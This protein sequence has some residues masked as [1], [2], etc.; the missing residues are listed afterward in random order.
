[1]DFSGRENAVRRQ[2]RK[3]S[4][5]GRQCSDG[6]ANGIPYA[7]AFLARES[8]LEERDEFERQ[9]RVR[10]LLDRDARHH[11]AHVRI[12]GLLRCVGRNEGAMKLVHA[13][14]DRV[15]DSDCNQRSRAGARHNR[16]AWGYP[17]ATREC[18]RRARVPSLVA[19]GPSSRAPQP[20]RSAHAL[21][22]HLEAKKCGDGCIFEFAHC[23]EERAEVVGVT[24]AGFE[25]RRPPAFARR[26]EVAR[27]IVDVG[28]LELRCGAVGIDAAGCRFD[29]DR[30]ARGGARGR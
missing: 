10:S 6:V 28:A 24:C 23:D 5:A 20:V 25:P 9:L 26:S 1:M 18:K 17:D 21:E 12:D 15:L 3:V 8:R 30:F 7:V 2:L 19:R 11:R 27:A 29:S 16:T 22:I 14:F 4:D 13:A